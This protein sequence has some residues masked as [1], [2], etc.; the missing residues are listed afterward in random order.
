MRHGAA[1]MNEDDIAA[2]EASLDE[3]RRDPAPRAASEIAAELALEALVTDQHDEVR[4]VLD[5]EPWE[6][7]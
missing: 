6:K 2:V 7:W 4:R 5:S 3:E 1:A